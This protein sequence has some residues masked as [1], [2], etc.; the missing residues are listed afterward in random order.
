[1][2]EIKILILKSKFDFFDSKIHQQ[3][4]KIKILILKSKFDFDL[5]IIL[6]NNKQH[7]QQTTHNKQHTQRY[8]R[9]PNRC[10]N[11]V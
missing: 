4:D 7:T 11:C 2:F 6:S 1:M 8:G 10:G 3:I 9:T 5:S